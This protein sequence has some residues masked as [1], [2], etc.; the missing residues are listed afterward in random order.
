MSELLHLRFKLKT[1]FALVTLLAVVF[2][3]PGI[4]NQ[5][6]LLRFK[7]Y[8]NRNLGRL[9]ERER[10][11]L[12]SI[13]DSVLKRETQFGKFDMPLPWFL[14]DRPNGNYVLLELIP[15]PCTHS[16]SYA[17]VTIFKGNGRLVNEV[18]F[19]TG[20]SLDVVDA[21]RIDLGGTA[22]LVFA[23]DSVPSGGPIDFADGR[24][25]REKHGRGIRKQYYAVIDNQPVLLRLEGISGNSMP[26][27][28]KADHFIIGPELTQNQDLELVGRLKSEL[29]DRL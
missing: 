15:M 28:N 9:S 21:E 20:Y 19:Q 8:A 2:A 27:N 11:T 22:E 25:I 3:A 29:V 10:L 26:N 14:W 18:Q 6:Q 16:N 1:L 17:R 13:A 12:T 23:I 4:W 24:Y 7:S 5:I